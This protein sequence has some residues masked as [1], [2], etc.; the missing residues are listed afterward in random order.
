MEDLGELKFAKK[1]NLTYD[2]SVWRVAGVWMDKM[3]VIVVVVVAVVVVIIVVKRV[4]VFLGR[5]QG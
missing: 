3:A 1:Q 5:G 4:A 2:L